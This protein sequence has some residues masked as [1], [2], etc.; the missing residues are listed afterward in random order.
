M[1]RSPKI[2]FRRWLVA[3]L[4]SLVFLSCAA[5][6][7]VRSP[8]GF[9]RTTPLEVFCPSEND[10]A[11][12]AYNTAV[13][14]AEQGQ[15]EEAKKLYLKAIELDSGFCDAMD[16]L[17]QLYRREWKLDKAEYWYK[18]SIQVF[19]ENVV[20]RQN[21][22]LVYKFQ[23]KNQEAMQEYEMLTK[24][25]PDNPEGYYG[26]GTV[27]RDLE[28]YQ[29]A[30]YNFKRA[31]ELYSATSS[32]LIADAQ[33][34]LGMAYILLEDYVKARDYLEKA[35]PEFESDPK[36]NYVLGVCYLQEELED[37]E[38]ARKYLRKAKELGF[39]P[40]DE[41]LRQLD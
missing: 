27:Y 15:V 38:L 10:E 4:Y 11:S 40:A 9:I 19:P 28:R 7:P 20:A 35:Y 39:E 17:G 8:E 13:E 30:L 36:V 16:N 1:A 2:G 22:A 24:I 29:D 23:G 41:L 32:P 25:D 6:R 18:R 31:E 14:L 33:Q 3:G 34:Q 5:H 21:L 37:I 12:L 26:L